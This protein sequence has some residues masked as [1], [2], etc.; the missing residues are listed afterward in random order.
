M[1]NRDQVN[2][3]PAFQ[4]ATVPCEGEVGDLLVLTPLAKEETDLS[5]SGKASL[6]FCT[7]AGEGERPAKWARV[8]FDGW[9]NCTMP[10]PNPPDLTE[11][12]RG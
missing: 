9:A 6:W 4:Q 12:H 3:E 10:I 8:Q 5:K 7:V 1:A 2:I 11:L